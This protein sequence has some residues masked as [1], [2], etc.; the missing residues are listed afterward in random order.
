MDAP[1]IFV[2]NPGSTSTKLA[3]FEGRTPVFDER[4]EHPEKDI[5]DFGDVASQEEYRLGLIAAFLRDRGIGP[6]RLSAVAARGGLMKPVRS[7][8]YRVNDAMVADLKASKDRWGREHASNLG[9]ILAKRLSDSCSIP[10]FTADPVTVDEMDEVARISGV[11]EITRKSHLHALNIKAVARR[12]ARETGTQLTRA[13]FV[14]AHVG[15][16]VSVA[17]VRGGLISDVNNALLGMGPFSPSRAGALPTGDLIDMAYSGRYEKAGLESKLVK[18]S[19]LMGYLGTSDVREVERRI[20]AGDK[21]AGMVFAAMAYQV[22]K[23]IAA[24]AAA[25]SGNVA[26]VILT[27]GVAN[28]AR[29][30]DMVGVRTGFIAPVLVYPGEAEMEALAYYAAAALSGEEKVLEYG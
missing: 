5:K 15:G 16:G 6:A 11:P 13:N 22:A 4:I 29:F 14:V 19:G 17:A 8:V 21:E 7:G 30:T 28:S 10:A 26:A 20:D 24:M 25:L 9:C 18:E 27:G 23:E 2:I 12:A 3:Y 1:R